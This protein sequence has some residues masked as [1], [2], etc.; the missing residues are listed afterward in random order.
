MTHC[1]YHTVVNSLM[2]PINTQNSERPVPVGF[3]ALEDEEKRPCYQSPG[4][5]D[6]PCGQ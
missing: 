5:R 1:H 4:A 3:G 2:T 6:G